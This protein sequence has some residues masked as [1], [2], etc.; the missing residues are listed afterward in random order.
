MKKLFLRLVFLMALIGALVVL[1]ADFTGNKVSAVSECICDEEYSICLANC[2]SGAGH[3][4]C[5]M[6]C[7]QNYI[8][9]LAQYCSGK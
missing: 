2:P 4:T 8:E 7:R 6:N 5:V 3:F 9:C 1:P